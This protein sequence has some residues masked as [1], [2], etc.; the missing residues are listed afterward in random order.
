MRKFYTP[1]LGVVL[2]LSLIFS[3]SETT[4]AIKNINH[5]ATAII[6]APDLF[7]N[8]SGSL[9]FCQGDS[10]SLNVPGI[11]TNYLWSNGATTSCNYSKF[12]WKFLC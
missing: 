9:A 3:S 8:S 6:V 2:T 11:Y 10:V 7:I 4:L 12:N 1:L 5:T